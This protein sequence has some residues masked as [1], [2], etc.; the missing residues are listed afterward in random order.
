[1]KVETLTVR[2]DPKT[3]AG[4]LHAFA[5]EAAA[6]GAV[7]VLAA[8]VT[9]DGKCEAVRMGELDALEMA[10]KGIAAGLASELEERRTRFEDVTERVLAQKAEP[11]VPSDGAP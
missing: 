11:G 6:K 10:A 3:P 7:S 4:V 8:Y 5:R 1:M 2:I 9:R